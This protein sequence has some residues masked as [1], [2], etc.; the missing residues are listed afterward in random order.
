M[1]SGAPPNMLLYQFQSK[2]LV[3]VHTG[4]IR[5]VAKCP[6]KSRQSWFGGIV[7]TYWKMGQRVL[8]QF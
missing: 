1:T 6:E 7:F 8:P 3:G 5:R 2:E 4:T